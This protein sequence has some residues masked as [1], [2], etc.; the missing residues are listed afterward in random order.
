[1][2]YDWKRENAKSRYIDS[3]TEEEMYHISFLAEGKPKDFEVIKYN[4]KV[5]DN[6]IPH[7]VIETKYYMPEL[8]DSFESKVGIFHDLNVYHGRFNSCYCQKEI[9]EYFKTIGLD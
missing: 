4:I 9:F 6:N 3:L 1:M 2:K 5:N 7:V 8:R